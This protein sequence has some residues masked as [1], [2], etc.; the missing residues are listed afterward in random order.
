MD[1][2]KIDIFD[3]SFSDEK[4]VRILPVASSTKKAG[5]DEESD[6][7]EIRLNRDSFNQKY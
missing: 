7:L 2:S 3:F 5:L 1:R 6:L 4:T